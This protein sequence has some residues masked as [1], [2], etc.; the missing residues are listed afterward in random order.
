MQQYR[1]VAGT[2]NHSLKLVKTAVDINY[3]GQVFNLLR[4]LTQSYVWTVMGCILKNIETVS[5]DI[6]GRTENETDTNSYVG[7]ISMNNDR[8]KQAGEFEDTSYGVVSKY[9]NCNE[10]EGG[11]RRK[12][13]LSSV[14]VWFV[15]QHFEGILRQSVVSRI[16]AMS[17]LL[18][19]S[20]MVIVSCS[21]FTKLKFQDVQKRTTSIM[22]TSRWLTSLAGFPVS[23]LAVRSKVGSQEVGYK[24]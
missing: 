15:R 7:E 6:Q 18:I 2:I 23:R 14:K 4:L 9:V 20:V 22:K 8:F 11:E 21:W 17:L 3:L 13:S 1:N 16:F 24:F 5:L 12:V 19:V 10:I